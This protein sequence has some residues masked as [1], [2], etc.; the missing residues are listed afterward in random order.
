MDEHGVIQWIQ[1][2]KLLP[3]ELQRLLFAP[4]AAAPNAPN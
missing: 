4:A 1:E 2:Q 3:E